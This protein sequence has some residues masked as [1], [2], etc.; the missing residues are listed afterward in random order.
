MNGKNN[1]N[2]TYTKVG[3]YYIPDLALDDQPDKGVGIYGRMREQYLKKTTPES[4]IICSCTGSC[5]PI[6]WKLTKRRKT[7]WTL[8]FPAWLLP[9]ASPKN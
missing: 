4:T 2:L 6:C 7:T 8:S 5:I 3:D 1:N 9:L